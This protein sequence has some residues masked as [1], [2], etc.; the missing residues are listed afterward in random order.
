MNGEQFTKYGNED[1]FIDECVNVRGRSAREILWE[2]KE[3]A[4]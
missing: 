3:S 1:D 2:R 4:N